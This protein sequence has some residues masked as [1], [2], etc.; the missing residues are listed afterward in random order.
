MYKLLRFGVL[1]IFMNWGCGLNGGPRK[2]VESIEEIQ[3]E[4]AARIHE[5]IRYSEDLDSALMGQAYRQARDF[6]EEAVYKIQEQGPY[7]GDSVL[8]KASL[9]LAKAYQGVLDKEIPAM[10]KIVSKPGEVDDADEMKLTRL[11]RAVFVKLAD[12]EREFLKAGNEFRRKYLGGSDAEEA[13]EGTWFE[14]EAD[15]TGL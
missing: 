2:Y 4:L 10:V 11:R 7:R 3:A 9:H 8:Y 1:L 14:E 15:T 13:E 6:A 5:I 12:A